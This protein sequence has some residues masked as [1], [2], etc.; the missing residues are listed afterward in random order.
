MPKRA[1]KAGG[2]F[3]YYNKPAEEVLQQLGSRADG[4]TAAEAVGLLQQCGPNEIAEKMRRPAWLMF[5]AQFRS[6]LILILLAATVVAALLGEIVDAA[7]IFA[8]VII[9]ALLG[10]RHEWKAERALSALK[11]LAAP[12]AE[13]IRDGQKMI[14]PVSQIVPGDVIALKVGDKVPADCRI[15]SHMNLRADEAVLTGESTPVHKT[16]RS[17]RGELAVAEREN[18]LFAGTTVVYGHGH[19]VVTATGMETEFGRIARALQMPEEPTPLQQKLDALGKQLGA[20][21][22]IAVFLIFG[23]GFG[24]GVAPLEMFLTAVAL[25]VAAIPEALPAVTTITLAGGVW[26]MAQHNA[27]VRRLGSV[28]TLGATTVICSDKTGTMTANEMTVR[29]LYVPSRIID[30]T[31]E[32]YDAGGKF[33]ENGKPMDVKLN[34][35]VRLLLSAGLMCNDAQ[36]DGQPVGDPTE[37]ALLVAARKGGVDDLRKTYARVDEEPFDSQRKMMSVVCQVGRKRI[38]YSKGAVESVLERCTHILRDGKAQRMTAEDRRRILNVNTYFAKQALRVIALAVKN[39]KKGGKSIESDLVFIG[40]QGMMD[41]PRPEV[42]AAIEKCKKA[43]IKVVMITG[44]HRDTALAVAKELGLIVPDHEEDEIITGAELDTLDEEQFAAR[45][46]R[47]KV[48]ARVSPEHKVRITEAWRDKGEIVAMTG[49]GVNDAPALKKADIGIAMGVTGTDVAREAADMILTDDNFATIEKAVEHGRSIYD[50][51]GKFIRY[52]LSCNIGEVFAVFAAM[53]IAFI[54]LRQPLLLLLPAQILWMN[55]L[56]DAL[57]AIALGVERPEPDIMQRPPRD[58]REQIL[59]KSTFGWIV[60][61]GALMMIG[62]TALF[63]WTL[64][65]AELAVAQTI[66]FSALV[67][68]QM[69]VALAARSERMIYKIGFLTNRKLLTAIVVSVVL[70]VAVVMLPQLNL[71]FKT[72]PLQYDAWAI[73]VGLSIVLFAVL[74]A[75]KLVFKRRA[76]RK[77]RV[78]VEGWSGEVNLALSA[79]E[80]QGAQE[81][82]Q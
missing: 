49:D 27:I 70:Q 68:F 4:L 16:E 44:D 60:F 13:V 12:Q 52:L 33:S 54:W 1:T 11:K 14:I 9:N 42:R 63:F 58:P 36:T 81:A 76:E 34:A 73:I 65:H 35:D 64:G 80:Q 6:I 46:E 21:V 25:A 10:F 28:E 3:E 78:R 45:V 72:F 7:V 79:P 29:K 43:G 19:A 47:I 50:N 56:T 15:I 77:L 75:T 57:P 82:Q 51:I 39:M 26:A 5:L 32:G 31:G 48:Y 22:V 62:T 40:L 24:V 17:L 8:I 61:V 53:M 23:A 67:L 66:A 2:G 41:P 18:M 69:A 37:I 59:T 74:E 20:I 55:I 38:V 30:I 71:I